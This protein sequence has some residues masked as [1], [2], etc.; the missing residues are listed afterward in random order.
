[1]NLFYLRAA[2]SNFVAVKENLAQ[3]KLKS[4]GANA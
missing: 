3:I 1:M 4:K 2:T